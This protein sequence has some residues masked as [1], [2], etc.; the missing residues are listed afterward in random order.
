MFHFMSLIIPIAVF[1]PNLLFFVLPPR[2][3]PIHVLN[4]SKFI[5]HAAE[6]MGR[7]GV[8]VLPIFTRMHLDKQHEWISFS[9]M[10]VFL[11]LYYSGWLRYF[12]RNRDYQLLFAP[13]FG[14]P[15][16][17]AISPIL[18]FLCAAV[19]LHSS[20]LFLS[21]LILAVGHIPISLKTYHQIHHVDK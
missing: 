5:Y 16:P 14:I 7:V 6:G 4:K 9:G 19:I 8:M 13:M 12:K 15:V 3:V 18:Y 1:L 11:L 21:S 17:L 2:N 20:I 10:V